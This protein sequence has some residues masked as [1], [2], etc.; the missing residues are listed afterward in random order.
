MRLVQVFKA[1]TV[2]ELIDSDDSGDMIDAR[3]GLNA[4]MVSVSQTAIRRAQ[5]VLFSIERIGMS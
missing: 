2:C 1:R 4:K 5:A 3:Y